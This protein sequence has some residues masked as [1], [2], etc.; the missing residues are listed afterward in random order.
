MA[1]WIVHLRIAD[2]LLQ[3]IEG[4]DEAY[5]SIGNIAPD[6]GIPDEKWEK[7]DPSPK[8]L[9]FLQENSNTTRCADLDFYR[10][11]L[12]P[13]NKWIVYD[14]NFSFRLGY[15]FHL[16]TDNL[17]DQKIGIPTQNR[18][19]TEFE[20]DPKFIWEVKRDW[21][22]LDFEYVRQTPGSLFWRIFLNS[23][24]DNDFLDFLPKAAISERIDYI[25]KFYQRRDEPIE[26]RYIKR[27]G[28][29]LSN[30]ELNNFLTDSVNFLFKT[31]Q[32]LQKNP[33]FSNECSVLE[34]NFL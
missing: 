27:P 15:F 22:G 21:Y 29:Y 28:L 11:N 13:F 31:Y 7:F 3:L 19:N 33:D 5:F 10:S 20:A 26:N 14:Q 25:K 1:T 18:F 12:A 23:E 16:I 8:I 32:Y 24:Y 4:L 9:H 2:S 34:L 6:S 17:W 30:V